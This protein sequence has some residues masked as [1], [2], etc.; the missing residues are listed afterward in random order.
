MDHSQQL[1][2]GENNNH[3]IKSFTVQLLTFTDW[4]MAVPDTII[5]AHSS[6]I[7]HQDIAR[8]AS[9]GGYRVECGCFKTNIPVECVVGGTT[10]NS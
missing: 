7:P 10:V 5:P 6:C 2:K 9:I 3:L 4:R 1:S 8:V